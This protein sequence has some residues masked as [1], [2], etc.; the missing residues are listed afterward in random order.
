MPTID[1]M[2]RS[3]RAM[4]SERRPENQMDSGPGDEGRRGIQAGYDSS[5]AADSKPKQQPSL[6]LAICTGLA[7]QIQVVIS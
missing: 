7:H 4:R 6:R 3:T 5:E 2:L 1:M